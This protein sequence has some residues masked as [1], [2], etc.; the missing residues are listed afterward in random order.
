MVSCNNLIVRCARVGKIRS[1]NWIVFGASGAEGSLSTSVSL[2]LLYF[3][4]VLMMSC[5]CHV[6]GYVVCV[7]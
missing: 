6:V 1:N 3:E 4:D 5:V 2:L 7:C